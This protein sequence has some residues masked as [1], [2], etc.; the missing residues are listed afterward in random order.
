MLAALIGGIV[1]TSVLKS[2]R[3]VAYTEDWFTGC[4][5]LTVT[6]LDWCTFSG[7]SRR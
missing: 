4:E 7:P 3:S 2:T 5:K 1:L 6:E